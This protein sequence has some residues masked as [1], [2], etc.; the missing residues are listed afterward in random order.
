MFPKNTINFKTQ[1]RVPPKIVDCLSKMQMNVNSTPENTE[2]KLA[3]KP[4]MIV[5]LP[6]EDESLDHS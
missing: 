1:F 6:S 4:L 5:D 2:S 3:L